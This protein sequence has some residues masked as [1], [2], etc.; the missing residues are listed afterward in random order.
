MPGLK[1]TLQPG[2]RQDLSDEIVLA[3]QR[4]TLAVSM[5]PKESQPTNMHMEWQFDAYLEPDIEGHLS[6][7]DRQVFENHTARE[8]LS[9]YC[10][11]FERAPKVGRIAQRINDVAGVGRKKE[12]ARAIAKALIVARRDIECRIL[13]AAEGGPETGEQ[14]YETRGLFAWAVTALQTDTTSPV[15][16][17][18][19]AVSDAVYTG[20]W[21]DLTEATFRETI[22]GAIWEETGSMDDFQL[23]VGRQLKALITG[24]TIYSPNVTGKTVV[25]TFQQTGD[26]TVLRASVDAIEGDFGSFEITATPWL[27]RDLDMSV[28]A[29]RTIAQ[30]SGLIWDPKKCALRF[31]TMPNYRGFEDQGGGPRGLVEA[32]GGLVCYNPKSLG[33]IMPTS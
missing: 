18:A 25:R 5:I 32:I 1:S 13:S 31:E 4:N 2:V 23:F 10:Q 3:D 14:P 26:A 19:K 22:L 16:E 12:M 20:S 6:D 29:N 24:W 30:R 7:E 28:A 21:A 15:P 9:A 11:I 8:R 17:A 27:R 33:A